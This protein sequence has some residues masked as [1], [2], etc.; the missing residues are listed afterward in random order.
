L[1]DQSKEH[2]GDVNN[3]TI[4]VSP[5]PQ[6]QPQFESKLNIEKMNHSNNNKKTLLRRKKLSL[7]I[8]DFG[9]NK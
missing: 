8:L 1:K 9:N 4:L 2:L 7:T 6:P 3:N 5:Q